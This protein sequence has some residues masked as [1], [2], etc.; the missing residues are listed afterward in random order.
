[1]VRLAYS[2][3]AM[4]LFVWGTF[5]A[6]FASSGL[7]PSVLEPGRIGL[8][9]SKP[10]SRTTLLLGRYV[11]NVLIVSLNIVYLIGSIWLIVG[12]KTQ[13]WYPEFLF[14][15]PITIFVFAVLLC[16]VV[17]I[18][19]VFESAAV[20]VMVPIALM[21]MSAI[22]A[23]KDRV[24][25]LLSSEWSRDM[26]LTLYWTLP[27]I[28]DLGRIMSNLISDRQAEWWMA[29]W[30]SAAFGAV[31]LAGAVQVFRRRDY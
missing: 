21:L 12:W 31:V 3:V 6:I 26:W 20:A 11:G 16:V 25:R 7:I 18:G 30:S 19:V 27:K 4:F 1:V 17:L 23:Q 2:R 22:L 10:V 8:L 14:T 13:L 15:I 5:L 9:L 24:V 28:W 29:T